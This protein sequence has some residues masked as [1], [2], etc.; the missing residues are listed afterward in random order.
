MRADPKSN[1]GRRAHGDSDANMAA[2]LERFWPRL[3]LMVLDGIVSAFVVATIS[4]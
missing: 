1:G 4:T 2:R 3:F